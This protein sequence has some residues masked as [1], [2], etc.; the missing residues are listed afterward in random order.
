M[1]TT[2][3]R[4]CPK[5]S[6]PSLGKLRA[7]L[8]A[9]SSCRANKSFGPAEVITQLSS[10]VLEKIRV[11]TR[12]GITLGGCGSAGSREKLRRKKGLLKGCGQKRMPL[13]ACGQNRAAVEHHEQA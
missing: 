13:Y 11:N 2:Q 5:T 8:R 6:F 4:S 7:S 12:E 1:P 9:A 3:K 10:L